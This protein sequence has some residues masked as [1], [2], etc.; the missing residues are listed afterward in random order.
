[1]QFPWGKKLQSL[2]MKSLFKTF[3]KKLKKQK[4]EVALII[5]S[6]FFSSF[7]MFKTFSYENGHMLIATKAWSDFASHIPLIRSFSFGNNFPPEYPFFPGLPIKYH[8][9]FYLIVGF[10]EK[11]GIRIDWALNLPSIIGFFGLIILIYYFAK[12]LFESKTVGILSVLLFLFNGSL[13]FIYFIKNNATSFSKL[14]INIFNNTDFSSFAPYYGNGIV[15]AFW[16]LNIYTNQRHLGLSYA[17]SLLLFYIIFKK[18]LSGKKMSNRLIIILG[19]I[20]GLS[21]LLNMAVYAMTMIILFLTFFLFKKY[22]LKT[23]LLLIIS[24]LMAFPFYFYSQSSSSMSNF[25]FFP[26]YLIFDNLNLYSFIKYWFYNLGLHIFLI[27][28][29]FLLSPKNIKKVLVAF[30][31]LFII[32][33]LFRFSPEIAANHKFFNYFMIIGI[34]FSAYFLTL[35]WEKRK[36]LKPVAILLIFLLTFSGIIDFFPIY[37]DKKISLADYQVNKDVRWIMDNTPK[38]AVFLNSEYLYTPATLAGRKIF[39]GWPYFAWSQ[40]Y[41]TTERDRLKTIALDASDINQFCQVVQNNNLSYIELVNNYNS[42]FFDKNFESIY[43]N[44]LTNYS[45]YK[46]EKQCEKNIL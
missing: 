2:L 33:N 22:Q 15:S 41:N 7:L 31:G 30:F 1:M 10:F 36:I 23:F 12:L 46:I 6:I 40:G 5:S 45:I 18:I 14:F 25:S 24:S 37:N 42:S 43:K 38:D 27:P 32:A 3:I 28:I 44:N 26:G 11:I 21:F 29:G 19:L 35:L 17:L 16:N 4:T 20:L 9:L 13:S 8:Y 39:L 34:M